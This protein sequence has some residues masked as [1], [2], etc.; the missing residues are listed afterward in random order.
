MAS[1]DFRSRCKRRR[2]NSKPSPAPSV[3]PRPLSARGRR[4]RR[5]RLI[6][7]YAPVII[8]LGAAAAAL[9][10]GET[11]FE[12]PTAPGA[13]E[14]ITVTVAAPLGATIR[15]VKVEVGERVERGTLV[16][17]LE[18]PEL[19]QELTQARLELERLQLE[20]PAQKG[21]FTS[22]D[23]SVLERIER[24]ALLAERA[25]L[26]D[27]IAQAD[28]Q[29]DKAELEQ[30]QQQMTRQQE[31]VDKRL[32]SS[33]TLDSLRVKSAALGRAVTQADSL[34]QKSRSNMRAAKRRYDE[35]RKERDKKRSVD[36]VSER[37]APLEAEVRAQQAR[38]DRLLARRA[39]LSVKAPRD[40]R[41]LSISVHA[42]DTT[43]AG[44]PL[45]T[46]VDDNPRRVIA[47]TDEQVAGKIRIGDAARV[48]P[49][50]RSADAQDA[51]VVALGAGLIEIPARFRRFP[52][53]VSYGRQVIVQFDDDTSRAPLPGQAFDVVFNRASSAAPRAP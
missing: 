52:T 39:S 12:G 50:D 3:E 14:S 37:I 31:L 26:D 48:R 34:L 1:V 21:V 20:V 24:L 28:A 35:F 13:A 9:Y 25:A 19:E 4:Q 18:A 29:R 15:D 49:S 46:L 42:G 17:E 8:W 51:R 38:I 33:K 11:A 7:R 45:L 53:E 32:A 30:I 36:A 6:R 5:T 10:L 16:L 27:A 2:L 43:L 22:D 40:G 44:A 47:W 41:V 23:V